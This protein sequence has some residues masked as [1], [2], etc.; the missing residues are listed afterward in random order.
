M[1][2]S[3]IVSLV[4]SLV[5]ILFQLDLI[6]V[7]DAKGTGSDREAEQEGDELSLEVVECGETPACEE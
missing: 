6:R 3:S 5:S 1:P 7:V 4:C 2:A